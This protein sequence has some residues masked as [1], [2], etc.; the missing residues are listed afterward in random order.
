MVETLCCKTSAA[1]RNALE[2]SYSLTSK[3]HEIEL[4]EQ[5]QHIRWGACFV[6]EYGKD[7]TTVCEQL[8]TIGA[9][10]TNTHKD[11]CFFLLD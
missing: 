2:T 1:V 10:A 6:Q 3:A 8:A 9:P 7:S 11:H 5:L 4:N